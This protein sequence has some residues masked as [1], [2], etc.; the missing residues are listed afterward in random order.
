MLPLSGYVFDLYFWLPRVAWL[1]YVAQQR[2]KPLDSFC[3]FTQASQCCTLL[4]EVNAT[5]FDSADFIP[6]CLLT[7]LQLQEFVQEKKERLRGSLA[8]PSDNSL[9]LAYFLN[10]LAKTLLMI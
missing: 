7:V 9:C 6:G 10:V 5:K 2:N 8:A 3:K 4:S 1:I